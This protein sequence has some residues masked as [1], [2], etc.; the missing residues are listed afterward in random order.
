MRRIKKVHVMVSEDFYNLLNHNR[1]KWSN[2]VYKE[3]GLKKQE[4]L[5]FPLYTDWLA[6]NIKFPGEENGQKRRR[7]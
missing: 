3:V 7:I 2:K 6:K 4:P 5:T 1:A